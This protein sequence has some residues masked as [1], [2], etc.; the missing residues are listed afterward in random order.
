MVMTTSR[1]DVS[2]LERERLL[3]WLRLARVVQRVEQ[4][5]TEQVRRHGLTMAQFDVLAQ[6]GAD[7]G[8]TQQELADKLF[9]TKGN[10]AQ[11]LDRM[12]Q[13]HL[14]ERR[15]SGTGRANRLFLTEAGDARR[16]EVIDEHERL[17]ASVFD[18]LDD[19]ELVS[20][21][22]SL[23]KVDRSLRDRSRRMPSL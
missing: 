17:A 13:R 23:R 6:V 1:G 10:I 14:V 4:L 8:C 18:G 7:T 2:G 22:R 20:L 5:L 19:D 16:A 11:L 12:E 3:T 15:P 21:R 9:V